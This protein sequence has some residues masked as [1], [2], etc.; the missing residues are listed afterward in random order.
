MSRLRPDHAAKVLP[1]LPAKHLLDVVSRMIQLGTVQREVLGDVE[2]TLH[3]ELMASL[4]GARVTDA[5]AQ[6]AEIFNRTDPKTL[7]SIFGGLEPEM[8]EAIQHIKDKMFTFED[9]AAVDAAGLVSVIKAVDGRLLATALKGAD[10][11]MRG[12]FIGALSPREIG[13]AHV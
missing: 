4:G 12:I 1:L 6:M 7:E 11:A 8:P 2:S 13:R 9:L 10:E 5:H 3:M